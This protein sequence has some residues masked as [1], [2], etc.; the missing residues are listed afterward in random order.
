VRVHPRVAVWAFLH[1][2]AAIQYGTFVLRTGDQDFP[3]HDPGIGSGRLALGVEV[4][5][6][7]P[8]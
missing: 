7:D 4:R 8:R 2:L 5:F 6:G 3:L 1:G